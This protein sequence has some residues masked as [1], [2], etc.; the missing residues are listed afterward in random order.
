MQIPSLTAERR[1][2]ALQRALLLR[3]A[4]ASLLQDIARNRA[5][6]EEVLERKDEV[7][8]RIRVRRVLE[9][10][11]GIGKVRSSALLAE[12]RIAESRRIRGLGPHQRRRLI[13]ALR[14]FMPATEEES[15]LS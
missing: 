8:G 11:H 14:P 9:A 2:E 15:P 3:R 4:R 10:F 13:D 6:L 1:A 5:S 12:L 7:A